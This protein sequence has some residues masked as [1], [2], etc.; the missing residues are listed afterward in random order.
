MPADTSQLLA[1]ARHLDHAVERAEP[2]LSKV[3]ARGA[4]NIKRSAQARVRAQRSGPFLPH[5]ARSIS[6]DLLAPLVAEIGPDG[7]KP[8]GGM[9]RGV[10]FGSARTPPMPHLFP[11][12]DEEEPKV[13]PFAAGILAKALA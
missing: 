5:Y 3:V 9:G 10:E 11:A 12:A 7:D 1:Y 2:E 6:Y 8:Q 4:F 13:G